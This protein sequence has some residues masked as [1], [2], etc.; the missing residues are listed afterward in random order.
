MNDYYYSRVSPW[1][2]LM[3]SLNSFVNMLIA[4][5]LDK[6]KKFLFEY[7]HSCHFQYQWIEGDNNRY[8]MYIFFWGTHSVMIMIIGNGYCNLDKACPVG[9]VCR[10]HWLH[11]CRRVRHPLPNK[12]PEMTLNN[13][14]VRFQKCWS[15]GDMQSTH[16]LPSLPAPLPPGVVASDKVL[17]MDQIELS[18]VLTLN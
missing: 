11:L 8:H 16:S 2:Y 5:L 10:I 15:S 1:K 3:K 4:I 12:C 18:C 17:S 6:E 14:M 7:L 13:L 9:W